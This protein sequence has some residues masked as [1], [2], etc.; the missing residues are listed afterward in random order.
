MTVGFDSS[1]TNSTLSPL[2][3]PY[4]LMPSM[5]G[6]TVNGFGTGVATSATGA[7]WHDICHVVNRRWPLTR[8]VL[9]PCQVQ[10]DG[11]AASVVAALDR[12]A[13]WGEQ[14]RVEG[15]PEDAPAVVILARGGGS[16]EDLWS[17]NDE[18]DPVG[19]RLAAEDAQASRLER[20]AH[21]RLAVAEDPARDQ[22]TSR[23]SWRRRRA[24]RSPTSPRI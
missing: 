16:L 22:P 11:A 2:G 17:F 13:R 6:P 4:S 7:V 10:G 9:S 8:L 14:C 5:E 20:A 21:F 3:S 23:P 12:L 19:L 24:S 15:R 18:R 1:G